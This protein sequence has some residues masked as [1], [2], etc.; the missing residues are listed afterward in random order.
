[1][2]EKPGVM[3]HFDMVPAIQTLSKE[4]KATLIET[5]LQYGLHKTKPAKL[6]KKMAVLWPLIQYRLDLDES[7]YQVTVLKRK[8]AAYAR[9]EK[10]NGRQP[11]HYSYW[12][13]SHCRE[14]H[15][16]D[17]NALA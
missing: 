12:L 16:E 7:R 3:I 2:K 13:K 10:E 4:D 1:M 6:S 5:L 15:K 14:V 9:W 8:Y 17:P 11:L